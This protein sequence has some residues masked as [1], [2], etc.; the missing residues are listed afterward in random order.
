[1]T[2][3]RC[4]RRTLSGSSNKSRPTS[5]RINFSFMRA[6]AVRWRERSINRTFLPG[7]FNFALQIT[8]LRRLRVEFKSLSDLRLGVVE[9]TGV[10][11]SL[12]KQIKCLCVA[13]VL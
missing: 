2:T 4:F 6:R 8:E 7:R 3:V 1:M 12:S 10:E 9:I 13:R 11:M 5:F